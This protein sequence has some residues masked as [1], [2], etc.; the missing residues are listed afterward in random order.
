MLIESLESRRLL[1][2]SLNSTT[3]LLTVT[4]TS[5]RDRI[6]I[7]RGDWGKL[8]VTETTYN[9]ATANTPA[10]IVQDDLENT[11]QREPK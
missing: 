6:T 2:A 1:S 9:A 10:T 3:G 11:Y 5:H 7:T 8:I 4:G